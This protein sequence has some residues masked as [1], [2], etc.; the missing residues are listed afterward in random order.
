[1]K[2]AIVTGAGDGIGAEISTH[3]AANGYRVG[4]LDIRGD[5]AIATADRWS[6]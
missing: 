2:T 1:M 6:G 4:V 5:L 3:L